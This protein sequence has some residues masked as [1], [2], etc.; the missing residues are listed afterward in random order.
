MLLEVGIGAAREVKADDSVLVVVLCC[1]AAAC[2]VRV[3]VLE[4]G[5]PGP[6]LVRTA[7]PS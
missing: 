7:Q 6:K 5:A 3:A 1:C 4:L 2:E